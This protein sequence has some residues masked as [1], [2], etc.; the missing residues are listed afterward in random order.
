MNVRHPILSPLKLRTQKNSIGDDNGFTSYF[1]DG[2]STNK[3]E[4][5]EE[6]KQNTGDPFSTTFNNPHQT[7]EKSDPMATT[8]QKLDDFFNKY[9]TPGG[10]PKT[11]KMLS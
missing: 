3:Q 9:Q 11:T 8:Q 5:E 4:E 1:F 7:T 10:A 2:G 6:E